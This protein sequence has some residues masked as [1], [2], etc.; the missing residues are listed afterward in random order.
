[1]K[2]FQGSVVIPSLL[3]LQRLHINELVLHHTETLV[4]LCNREEE[5]LPCF[6]LDPT[7]PDLPVVELDPVM[8]CK[9]D[10][11]QDQHCKLELRNLTV[12]L[13]GKQKVVESSQYCQT[14]QKVFQVFTSGVP[15]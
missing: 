3:L 6:Q 15:S 5:S 14:F 8:K 1:M 4:K 7:G 9:G 13:N 2:G 12:L 10:T 11:A